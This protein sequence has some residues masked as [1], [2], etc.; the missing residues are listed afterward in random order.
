MS[1]IEITS[2]ESRVFQPP[3]TFSKHAHIKG[4]DELGKLYQESIS[5]PEAFWAKQA[6]Q[7]DWFEKWTG[8]INTWD[9]TEARCTWFKGGKLNASFNCL[10]R[11][12]NTDRRN[13][14]AIIWEADNPKES[15]TFTYEQL[16]AEVCKFANVL[17]K[18]GYKKGDRVALYLPMIPELAIAML[19]CA[20]LGII[21]SIV[22]GGFSAD[23]LKDR[24][25]DSNCTLLITSDGSFRG[26]KKIPLKANADEALKHCP[27]VKHSII[28][29]RTGIDV[30]MKSKRDLW[31]HD[32]IADSKVQGDCTP[33]HQ[34]AEDSLFILYTSG[35]TGKP[36]GVLHTTGGYLTYVMTTFKWIFDYHE[37]DI[38]WCTADI[39][40]ITGHS[41]IIYGP[42]A[43]GATTLMFEGVPTYPEPDRFW[44][45]V[46]KWKVNQLYTAPTAI[47]AIMR[48]GDEWVTKHDLSSLKLLGSVGEP[49][50]PEAWI[51]Y[52][53]VVG[54]GKCPIVDTY[55][56]TETGGVLITPIPGAVPLKPGSC[57]LPFPGIEAMIVDESGQEVGVNE[58]GYLVIK[59]PWPG[60]MR[61]VYGD[62][63]RFIDTYWRT[64]PPYYMTGDGARRDEDGY[65]W[66]VGRIDDVVNVSGHRMGTAEI[67]S[68]LVSHEAV[69]EAAVVGFPHDIKGQALYCFVTLK[70]GFDK[71]EDLRQELRKHVRKEIGPIATPDKVQFAD[72]LPKTRSG[73]I[74]RRILKK[75]AAGQ[76]DDLGDTT[77]LADPSVV[78]KLIK[79]RV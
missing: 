66:V 24:I 33:E 42:L 60:M 67:E 65:F 28:V 8:P 51:W 20:R 56:Q 13:K 44:A 34:D 58:G 53:Q 46:E 4:L 27:N 3:K 79:E 52:H 37:D 57:T 18:L 26:G 43:A 5:D 68:A 55:W 38:Y 30:T 73:K 10:D 78:Q 31:W 48:H 25:L 12:L 17:K 39:G 49:I 36:K 63:Q 2:K 62:H 22:F 16:H 76:I 40:W 19:A 35:S 32:L 71:T 61:T 50:N 41:Y 45:I 6:E 54:K 74:M 15:R 11:H 77:T 70:Q 59:K 9:P 75:I 7:L 69:A 72:A 29:K 23:S 64:F 47:R 21:H 1:K 14:I